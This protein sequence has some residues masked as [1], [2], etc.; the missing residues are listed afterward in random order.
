MQ[1]HEAEIPVLPHV[2]NLLISLYGKEPIKATENNLPGMELKF[3]FMSIRTQGKEKINGE[4]VRLQISYRLMPFYN[5]YSNAFDLG[6]YFEKTFN[7]MLYIHI[8]AQ[9]SLHIPT[10]YAIKT[11]F[12]KY[13]IDENYYSSHAAAECYRRLKRK[14]ENKVSTG[15]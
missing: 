12:E 4:T 13:N 11:F 1:S 9:R 8:E 2:K 6:C 7:T 5:K 10:V 3:I 14:K 15:G